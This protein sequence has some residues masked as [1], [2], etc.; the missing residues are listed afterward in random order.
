MIRSPEGA[1]TTGQPWSRRPELATCA[2]RLIKATFAAAAARAGI[3]MSKKYNTEFI[4]VW[5]REWLPPVPGP[6]A[7]LQAF[8]Q[9]GAGIK[10]TSQGFKLQA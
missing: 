10:A 2:R 4:N 7:S 6:G 1:G 8:K 9:P 3:K 5:T